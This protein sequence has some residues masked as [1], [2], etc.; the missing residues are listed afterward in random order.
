M[1]QGDT[2]I[3]KNTI[4]K[5]AQMNFQIIKIKIKFFYYQDKQA[6]EKVQICNLNLLKQLII[7]MKINKFLFI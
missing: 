1:T 4:F 6:Q 2:K 7:E 5:R 3:K